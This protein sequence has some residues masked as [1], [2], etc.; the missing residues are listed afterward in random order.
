MLR[1]SRRLFA[2]T[3][4]GCVLAVAAVH[5]AEPAGDVAPQAFDQAARSAP[6]AGYALGKVRRWLDE[7]ALTSVDPE[8]KLLK[9]RGAWNYHNTAADCY[10]F[11]CWAAHVTDRRV[12][13]GPLRDVLKAE[14]ALCNHLDRIPAPYDFD[15][16]AKVAEYP[17]DRLMFG[18]SEYVK[19]GLIAIVEVT[20]KDE[21]FE[22]MVAIEEDLWKHAQIDTPYGK[23]PSSSEPVRGVEIDGEQLQALCRLYTMTGQRK[24]LTW[25][26]R[27]GDYYLKRDGFVPPHLRDHGCEIVGGL[28]LL[29]GV[30]SEA[31]PDKLREYLPPMKKM[32]DEILARGTNPDGFMVNAIEGAPSRFEPGSLSDGWGYNYVGYL[33]YD[34]ASG[35]P[36][37]RGRIDEALRNLAKPV[38]M[39]GGVAGTGGDSLADS[40]EGA[41][42]LLNRYPVPEGLAWLDRWMEAGL[43]RSDVPLDRAR[44][45]GAN[46][47][48]S[49][50]VRTVIMHALMHTRGLI[51]RPWRDDLVL[52]AAQAGGGLAVVIR[53][54]KP[55]SGKIV[56]DV[57]RHRHYLGFQR[58]WPRMNT[59]P[60]WFTV[61]PDGTYTVRNLTAGAETTCSGEHLH[62]GLVLELEPGVETRLLVQ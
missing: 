51:A 41:M 1:R 26:E 58:D 7:V 27:L 5:A 36:H 6:I 55:W 53:A 21:W 32:L 31:D 11:L 29:V 17:M 49:N 13:D 12:L 46:K 2:L 28:G 50:C 43:I 62:D 52:G 38:Y 60:E 20:G 8:T 54:E 40:A 59:L 34:M 57:P 10:P 25:A 9:M 33:C 56:F 16:K 44:L 15:A 45:W 19:D 48:E 35:E 30:E 3:A 18:A 61:E 22:R 24:F 39:E 47:W 4:A 37:Y 14:I 23:I 42:Y